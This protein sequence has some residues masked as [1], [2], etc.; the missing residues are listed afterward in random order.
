MR[1][2]FI[3]DNF[4]PEVNA[5]ATRTCEHCREWAADGIEVTVITCFPNFPEGK[6][7]DG[8][9]QK[10]YSVEWTGGIRVIRVFTYITANKGFIKRTIDYI[11]FGI[12]AFIAGLFIKTDIIVA[13]SPQFFSA[14]WAHRL[15]FLKRKPWIMEVRDLWPESV[16]TVGAVK[17]DLS[18]AYFTW[19]EKRLY[20]SAK[21]IVTLTDAFKLRISSR[22]IDPSKIYV[23]KNGANL[24]LFTP[25]NKSKNLLRE[26]NLE[27]KFVAGFIGTIGMAH[28]L[29]FIVESAMKINDPDIYFLFVGAG[30]EKQN[31]EDLVKRLKPSNVA[32]Y[33]LIPKEKVPDYLSI[34]DISLINLKKSE[35]FKT[36]I[37]SKIFESSAMEK[38]ILLGVDGEAR[39]LVEKYDAG[40]YFEPENESD[41]IS[42]LLRLK[43]DPAL[44][45]KLKDGCR[46][47]ARDFDRKK[48]AKEMEE[49]LLTAGSKTG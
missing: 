38:P 36:V 15:A 3:S 22:G 23:V 14:V 42:K 28:K 47:L 39:R 8:Y 45:S 37:P 33:D 21:L 17:N 49:I 20:K 5:P 18:L 29:D 35:T 11:S 34:L 13:T 24:E 12:A 46:N 41:F 43:N 30:A 1:L 19:L 10:L 27:T 32:I 44:Y 25:R 9:R 6:L 7:F 4:P 16:K 48:L 2:L 31:I 26:L 40:L